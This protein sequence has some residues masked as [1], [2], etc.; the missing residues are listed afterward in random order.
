MNATQLQQEISIIKE[1]IDKTRTTTAES[2]HLLVY[3]G[4]F[5]AIATIVIGVFGI[6]GMNDYIMPAVIILA[7]VN[8]IIGYRIAAK[9]N[10]SGK[11]ST[12]PK[13]LFWNILMVCGF[14]A[15]LIV[16]LF[17]FLGLYPFHAIPVLTSLVMG[18]AIFS[19]GAIFE[20]KFIQWTS[21]AWWIGACIMA[22]VESPFKLVTMVLII[23]I[24][25]I[26]PGL[27]LNKLYK[28]RSTK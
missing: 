16:F 25:W 5:S 12:Y 8:G 18:I 15:V 23:I 13:T 17:P 9:N 7:V 21:L 20:L 19:T 28:E 2:G 6:Y 14:T 27:Y 3:M 1:M 4:I 10:G 26:V 24:G 22:I 11:V